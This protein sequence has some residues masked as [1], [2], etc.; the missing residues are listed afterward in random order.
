MYK[1]GD[2]V[3]S[4]VEHD[5]W[6]YTRYEGLI[7]NREKILI[8]ELGTYYFICFSFKLKKFF[9]TRKELIELVVSC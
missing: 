6:Y 2:I 7:E 9:K 5:V 8:V 4:L 1:P 3:I